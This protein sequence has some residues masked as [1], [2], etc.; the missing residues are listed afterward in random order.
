[1]TRRGGGGSAL[2]SRVRLIGNGQRDGIGVAQYVTSRGWWCYRGG[3]AKERARESPGE[4][5]SSRVVRA[6]LACKWSLD[7]PRRSGERGKIE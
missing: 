3:S 7:E 4:R 5:E 1:M 2:V 6:S